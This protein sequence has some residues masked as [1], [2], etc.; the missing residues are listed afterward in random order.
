[1]MVRFPAGGGIFSFH[2]CVW[3]S[4]GAQLASYIVGTGCKMAVAW[5][6]FLT[7]I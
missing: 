7:S 3:I 2:H 6:W 1:M 4:S 5:S